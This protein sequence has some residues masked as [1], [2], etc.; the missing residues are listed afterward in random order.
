MS[1]IFNAT[2]SSI[3]NIYDK[4]YKAIPNNDLKYVNTGCEDNAGI[5]DYFNSPTVRASW[6]I[7]GDK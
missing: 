4:C 7:E 1:K 5:I 3:Y 6:N 2:N